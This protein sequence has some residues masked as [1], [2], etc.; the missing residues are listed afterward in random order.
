M[1]EEVQ[2]KK[3]RSEG[4][5]LVG[6]IGALGLTVYM[7]GMDHDFL[8][9]RFLLYLFTVSLLMAIPRFVIMTF[10]T[11]D[12][13][14]SIIEQVLFVLISGALLYF[15]IPMTINLVN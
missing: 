13:V 12:N 9:F 1:S 5:G 11:R 6:I 7:W 10:F 3:T 8:S 4:Y 14:Y 2:D 15:F